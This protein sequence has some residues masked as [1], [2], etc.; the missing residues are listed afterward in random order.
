MLSEKFSFIKKSELDFLDG[1]ESTEIALYSKLLDILRRFAQED[2]RI[3][4]SGSNTA[5][6]DRL[7][8]EIL[9][10]I[11]EST[12]L[13]KV[14]N[15]LTKFD[16]VEARNR[17]FYERILGRPVRTSL[18][19]EKKYVIESVT[20]ALTGQSSLNANFVNPIRKTLT[21]AV[22]F[23]QTFVEAEENLKAMVKGTGKGGLFRRYTGQVV[24]DSI[25]GFDGAVN[26]V[27]RDSFLLDGFRYVGSLIDDSRGNCIDLVNGSG[28]FAKFAIRPG[29]YRVK[30]LDRIIAL[31][32]DRKGWNPATT[33]ETFAQYR[34]GFNCRHQVF[35]FRLTEEQNQKVEKQL[36]A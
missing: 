10:V 34:G 26:D 7:K 35:Y 4:Q 9:K 3:I 6:F 1:I 17:T 20:D 2:G 30:D 15:F 13:P 31:A 14:S 12:F 22:R 11:R 23:N 25:N 32:K 28:V 24:T 5:L 16:G 8:K 33:K 27:I 18:T 29:T 19:L 21:D 36:S